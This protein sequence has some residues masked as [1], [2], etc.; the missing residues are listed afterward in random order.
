MCQEASNFQRVSPVLPAG[1][2]LL[3]AATAPAATILEEIIVTAQ[4]REQSIQ[5]V[6]IAITAFSGEQLRELGFRESTDV[7]NMTPG[8]T[9]SGNIGGQFLTFNIRGVNQSDFADLHESPN[10]V[11][12]DQVYLSLMQANRFGLFDSERVEILKGPQGTLYGR[13]A[14]GGL[15]HYITRKP[16]DAFESY[17]D[18]TYGSF[19]Q[20]RFEGAVSGP[21]T[22]NLKA[23]AAILHNRHDEIFNNHVPGVDDE[24]GESSLAG[25]VHLLWE[26]SPGAE[27]L[28]TGFGGESET[29]TAPWQAFPTV[30][31]VDANGNIVNTVKASP[32]ETRTGIGPGGA[33][34]CPL[35]LFVGP[36][37]V[38]G[39]DAFGFRDPDLHDR[40]VF[41][42]FADDD[43]AKYRMY[44]GTGNLTWQLGGVTLTSVTDYRTMQKKGVRVDVDASPN[45]VLGFRADAEND[46]FSQ[47]IRLSGE[48]ESARWLLGAY[49][50]TYDLDATQ[51]AFGLDP[52]TNRLGFIGGLQ[53]V[54]P[55]RVET[56]SYSLFGQVEYDLTPA[57]RMTTGLRVIREL[58]D[59]EHSAQI[60]L[61]DGTVIVPA[62]E[63]FPGVTLPNAQSLENND[64]LWAGK[65]QLDWRPMDD[66]LLYGGVSRGV[67]AGGFNQQLG[68]IFAIENFKYGS[69]ILTA[70]ETG[71]KSSL[72]SGTTRLNGSFYYYSYDDFQAHAANNL[73]FFVVNADA[74]IK[75]V[76]LELATQPLPGLELQFGFSYID[77]EV[78]NVPL[79]TGPLGS[80][81]KL[82]VDVR[83]TFTPEVQFSGLARYEW[84]AFANG[85]MAVQGDFS[86]SGSSFTN[87]TNFDSTK[88]DSYILG[89]LRLSYE[90]ADK[91]WQGD[92]FVKNVGDVL[93]EQLG[94]D[95][96]TLFG[97]SLR[98][99]L[100]PRW[101]GASIRYTWE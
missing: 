85:M 76:E 40:D 72:L 5:D 90:T 28:V 22:A 94:F 98:S 31:I 17:G 92:L 89:N 93:A 68:G 101:V 43:T 73:L 71:F 48:F 46:Q 39:A 7:V 78:Q 69:E 3:F 96:S 8:V 82:L 29:S 84:P 45:D 16:T 75:G 54:S 42:D 87:I 20:T 61:L 25:R 37:P 34:F 10:A 32:T 86:Y 52:T 12:I 100:P 55:A 38:P 60:L 19:N 67:K 18:F 36:R 41:K 59:F 53:F 65:I 66:L 4:K 15:V 51:G 63:G 35:C 21:L 80:G 70:Y 97:G 58:K 95:M 77:A 47:E 6:P 26:I 64:T 62:L 99:Y 81:Q 44:G 14:T 13:N 24:W 79:A 74:I 1:L 49:Y 83:P 88:M 27:L 56:D 57:L 9:A 23:R 50:L 30:S 91:R 33:Q 11:Y 2:L